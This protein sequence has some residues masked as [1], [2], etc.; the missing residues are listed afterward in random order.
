VKIILVNAVSVDGKIA[1]S[2]T[3]ELK[4]T[5]SEDK[6]WFADVSKK[7]GVIIMGRKAY[8][9]LGKPLKDRLIKV[10]TRQP[11]KY[12]DVA[13]RVEF[14]DKSPG[15]TIRELSD[16]NYE[17]VIIGGGA[18]INTIFLKEKLIDE[19]WLSVIPVVL[20]KGLEIFDNKIKEKVELELLESEKLGINGV[21]V[22]YKLIYR[23]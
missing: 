22:K 6:K 19:I 2:G 12:K 11:T 21:V 15:E 20:G 7:A 14:S 18:K 1:Q 10:M 13:G 16:R 23:L 17:E 4:W 5:G 9:V 3:D 8:E